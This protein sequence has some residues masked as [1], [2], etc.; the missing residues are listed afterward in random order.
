MPAFDLRMIKVGKYVNTAG[1]ITYTDQTEVGDAMTANL[2]LRYA[3]GRLYAKSA[4]AEYV[5]AATGGS[6]SIGVKY[7][8]TAAKKLMFGAQDSTHLT[9][10]TGLK[11][12]AGDEP[13]YVGVAFYGPSMVDGVE[14]YECV[15]VSKALF[16]PPSMSYQ[17]KGDSINFQTPTTS[18][19]FLPDDSTGRLMIETAEVDTEANALAWINDCL[20]ITSSTQTTTT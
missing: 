13:K 8:K 1:T 20:D 10:V 19:E 11:Y 3:E 6:I 17:T 14:K 7:I 18:G 12:S 15:F 16:G 2:E 4:L 5:K 9:S